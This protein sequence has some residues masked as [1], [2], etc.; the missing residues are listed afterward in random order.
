MGLPVQRPDIRQGRVQGQERHLLSLRLI[1][2]GP[3]CW[4]QLGAAEETPGRVL[5]IRRLSVLA[6]GHHGQQ[7]RR[8][9]LDSWQ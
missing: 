1:G 2:M 4:L 5:P 6:G 9:A 3:C 7:Q 8:D